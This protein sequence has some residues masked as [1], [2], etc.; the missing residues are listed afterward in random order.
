[1]ERNEKFF[2]AE[3]P[4]LDGFRLK[5]KVNKK[6]GKQYLII[7][8]VGPD[9][10]RSKSASLSCIHTAIAR[11]TLEA[12]ESSIESGE[13]P[14]PF[15]NVVAMSERNEVYLTPEE[16]FIAFKSWVAGISE[17]GMD[18]LYLQQ[19]IEDLA[20][21][22]APINL[23]LFRYI[24]KY[25][26][27]LISDYIYYINRKCQI[28]G[29]YH[30]PS[31]LANLFWVN[32][33]FDPKRNLDNFDENGVREECIVGDEHIEKMVELLY[34]IQFPMEVYLEIFE[35]HLDWK[36]LINYPDFPKL[37]K[38]KY[39]FVRCELASNQ[40]AACFYDY[41]FLFN[42]E[43]SLVILKVAMN[44]E[45]TKFEEYKTLFS[46]NNVEVLEAIKRNPNAVKFE[47]YQYLSN[48]IKKLKK[49]ENENK[50]E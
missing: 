17:A 35:D 25:N 32:E 34:T 26:F 7:Q 18:G 47:E 12:I 44:P 14:K 48:R 33:F 50:T 42:D 23:F 22:T 36:R 3:F 19:Q 46:R 4:F 28:D 9:N 15:L 13:Y 20:K 2:V 41:R 29:K 31:L 37:F 24:I 6:T 27:N 16:R 49:Q 21:F 39:W 10:K 43:C 1:M 11:T 30:I 5:A 45:A 40:I 38:C 8:H